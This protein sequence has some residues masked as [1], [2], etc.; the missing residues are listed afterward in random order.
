ME[1]KIGI[2]ERGDAG[3]D[4]AWRERIWTMTNGKAILIT[5]RLSDKFINA[6]LEE[7]QKGARIIIHCTCTGLGGSAIEPN[8]PRPELQLR[9]LKKLVDAGFPVSNLI[10]RVDPII[11]GYVG[12]AQAVLNTALKLGLLPA[13]SVKVSIMDCY[14]HV[15][16]RFQ[17]AG[18]SLSMSGFKPTW[19]QINEVNTMLRDYK[20]LGIRFT[21]CAENALTEATPAGCVGERECQLLG[22]A[23]PNNGV[24]PQGR[25][26]CLCLCGVKTE[27]LENKKRC[28]H[29][30]LYCYWRD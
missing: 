26:E 28:G 8:V 16:A 17:Q 24:N 9:Q 30:C 7:T 25:G 4:F 23:L 12:Y 13:I 15:A 20:A 11:P 2:T 22:I 1:N 18:I 14:K 10:L 27:L 3:L 6:V 21:T 5:K 19:E 29:G